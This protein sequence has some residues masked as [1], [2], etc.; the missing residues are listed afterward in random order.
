MEVLYRDAQLLVVNKPSGL[1]THRGWANDRDNA[2]VRARAIAGQY[3]FPA[4]RLDRA[5]SGVLVFALDKETAS[6]L[7]KLF[8]GNAVHKRYLALVRGIPPERVEVD[9]AL[10]EEKGGEDKKPARTTLRLLGSFERY[11][12]IEAL[13][14]TGRPHQIRRHCRH[15]SHPILGDTRYGNGEHNRIARTRFG[16]HR[17]ALHAAAL[18][19]AHPVTGEA[20]TLRAPLPEDLLEPLRAMQLQERAELALR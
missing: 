4:H 1:L 13:P 3:V 14:H 16:L 8:E 18:E 10:A 12:L 9:H 2:L 5:T 11:A 20:L 7:G 19:L 15:L 17:L 6:A